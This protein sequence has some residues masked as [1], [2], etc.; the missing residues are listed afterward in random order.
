MDL[1]SRLSIFSPTEKNKKFTNVFNRN[2]FESAAL[3]LEITREK[4]L[5]KY[6]W[7]HCGTYGKRQYIYP[8]FEGTHLPMYDIS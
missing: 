6:C 7:R 4:K 8:V 3:K 2:I 5:P 1:L